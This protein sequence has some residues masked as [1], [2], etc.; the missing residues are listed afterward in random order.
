MPQKSSARL[1]DNAILADIALQMAMLSQSGLG[2]KDIAA[3]ALDGISP[4]L[5]G[6][7]ADCLDSGM[8]LDEAMSET[9]V[10]PSYFTCMIGVGM[11]TGKISE[12]LSS[13]HLYYARLSRL[14]EALRRALLQPLAMLGVSAAIAAVILVAV[15]PVFHTAYLSAGM[16]PGAAM[17]FLS[18]M[19]S[20]IRAYWLVWTGC[21][22]VAALAIFLASRTR[23]VRKAVFSLMGRSKTG[24]ALSAAKFMQALAMGLD[25]GLGLQEAMDMADSVAGGRYAEL[26]SDT[27]N[28]M[29]LGDALLRHGLVRKAQERILASGITAGH[30]PDAV[31][32]VAGDLM[33][34]AE[35]SL[36][37]ISSLIEPAVTMIGT[38]VTGGMIVVAMLPLLDAMMSIRV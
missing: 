12:S 15:M 32:Y 16:I 22:A 20:H 17:L 30:L 2:P 10:F 7:V 25:S 27:R 29:A 38:A 23:A 13:L 1:L 19:G 3:S 31:N 14:N 35:K 21:M 28:G 8:Y 5:S 18:S 34:R 4:G 33:D 6:A 11:D 26:V 24:R 9:G 37:R 36:S